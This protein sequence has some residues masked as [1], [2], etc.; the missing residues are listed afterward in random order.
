MEKYESAFNQNRLIAAKIEAFLS[1]HPDQ[2]AKLT[3]KKRL[4]DLFTPLYTLLVNV[5]SVRASHTHTLPQC[6]S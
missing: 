2:V 3:L 1:H 5:T 6:G 4:A